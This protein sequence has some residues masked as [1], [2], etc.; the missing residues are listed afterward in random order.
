MAKVLITFIMIMLSSAWALASGASEDLQTTQK[1]IQIRE[2]LEPRSYK[3]TQELCYMYEFRVRHD[4]GL[5]ITNPVKEVYYLSTEI[6]SDIRLQR[7]IKTWFDTIG[8]G[9]AS[10]FAGDSQTF[11]AIATRSSLSAH[12]PYTDGFKKAV[13]EC[14]ERI[15]Q[16]VQKLIID[17][18]RVND[19]ITSLVLPGAVLPG[20]FRGLGFIFSKIPG[21]STLGEKLSRLGLTR[22]RTFA[23]MG[24]GMVGLVGYLS[25]EEYLRLEAQEEFTQ[26]VAK[27]PQHLFEFADKI[28]HWQVRR[29]RVIRFAALSAYR[30]RNDG[31][32]E[33]QI[34]YERERAFILQ[35]RND[36]EEK[37]TELVSKI[38]FN[39]DTVRK[40]HQI[41]EQLTQG[42]RVA[43]DQIQFFLDV[44]FAAAIE[45]ALDEAS[46]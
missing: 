42:D 25:W 5:Q 13:S 11:W 4:I 31:N 24:G 12:L 28:D 23:V 33:V 10:P 35:I 41:R 22:R 29:D 20:I 19:V 43:P 39:E 18:L 32:Q 26:H 36:L 2:T 17:D 46:Q 7:S 15:G 14:S 8:D 44:Q 34:A 27:D 3:I 37:Y 38:E 30:K 9:L 45:L 16:N 21:L 6:D 40:F 1:I